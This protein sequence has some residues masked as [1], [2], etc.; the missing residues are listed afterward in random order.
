M[1]GMYISA[2]AIVKPSIAIL[3]R[4][5]SAIGSRLRQTV[6]E[7]PIARGEI[8]VKLHDILFS[9]L[10]LGLFGNCVRKW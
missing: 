6:W 8:N 4:D 2:S 3:H 10:Y 9:D 1:K 7:S 5:W